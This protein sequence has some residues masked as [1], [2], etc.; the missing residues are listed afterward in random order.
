MRSWNK[1]KTISSTNLVFD[2]SSCIFYT[3]SMIIFYIL[4]VVATNNNSIDIIIFHVPPTTYDLFLLFLL[5]NN[6]KFNCT[7]ENLPCTYWTGIK[8]VIS[9]TVNCEFAF[10]GNEENEVSIVDLN[11]L[12]SNFDDSFHIGPYNI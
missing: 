4:S 11:A 10:N 3:V 12:Y 1:L 6:S 9:I 7:F 5:R 2:A 8:H